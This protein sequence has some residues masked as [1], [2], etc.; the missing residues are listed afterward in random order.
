MITKKIRR[1]KLML[2][3]LGPFLPK[4][5]GLVTTQSVFLAW[6]GESK[7]MVTRAQC[8]YWLLLIIG[9]LIILVNACPVDI[10][11]RQVG[12]SRWKVG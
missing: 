3:L 9:G 5:S 10:M 12:K 1:N 2:P 7:C 4:L 11:I 8:R 6:S